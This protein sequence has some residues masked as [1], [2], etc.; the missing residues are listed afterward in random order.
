MRVSV[1]LPTCNRAHLVGEAIG[2]VLAQTR[3]ADEILVIDDGSTDATAARLADFGDRIRVLR[4][5]GRGAAAAR[6]AGLAAATG[7]WVTFLDDD[8]VWTPDRLAVLA[9]D[10][11]GAGPQIEVHVADLRY[12]G[13]GYAWEQM[14][15]L[16]VVA[17]KGR[18]R[19]AEDLFVPAARGF[20]LNGLAC[21]R[22]LALA[23]GG[24]EETLRTHEDKLFTGLL[25]QGRPW[26]VTGDVVSEVR[27]H[28]GDAQALTT[29]SAADAEGRCRGMLQVNDRFL[30]LPLTPTQRRAVRGSRNFMLL[31]LAGALMAKGDRAGARRALIEAARVH[32]SPSKGWAKSLPALLLGPAGLRWVGVERGAWNR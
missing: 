3:S 1:I 11:A 32:P 31:R 7:D 9:R 4:G 30:G 10:L 28:A 8:D 18:A 2:S 12:V 24:F 14:A 16:G 13:P 20:Q 5:S 27:R 29:V 25:G 6:N 23:V 26:L 19:R 21:T 22:R 17:P 15:M